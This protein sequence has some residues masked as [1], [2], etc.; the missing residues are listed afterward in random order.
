MKKH[1]VLPTNIKKETR[2]KN[3]TIINSYSFTDFKF[4]YS[5]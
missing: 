4:L 1:L 3:L 5:I 2:E